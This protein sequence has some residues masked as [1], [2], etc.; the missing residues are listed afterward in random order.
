MS[1]LGVNGY[2]FSVAGL[3]EADPDDADDDDDTDVVQQR[4]KNKAE[5][6]K[7]PRGWQ[8]EFME[9]LEDLER[10]EN[11]DMHEFHEPLRLRENY[12]AVS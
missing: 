6:R 8:E 7:R 11:L 3:N 10:Q 9:M 5:A 12:V 1:L 2:C 4:R